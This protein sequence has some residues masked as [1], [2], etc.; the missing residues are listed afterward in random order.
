MIRTFLK[1]TRGIN[2]SIQTQSSFS[3]LNGHQGFHQPPNTIGTTHGSE[4][5]FVRRFKRNMRH[6]T[7]YCQPLCFFEWS[8]SIW[9]PYSTSPDYSNATVFGVR[10]LLSRPARAR[11]CACS[12]SP[13]IRTAPNVPSIRFGK[14]SS[15]YQH[16]HQYACTSQPF[17]FVFRDKC[18]WTYL[19]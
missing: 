3:F 17:E 7:I 18:F 6:L 2:S 11:S 12:V 14:S 19:L 10:S 4:S 15:M 13:F 8:L 9:N 5:L 1:R 16:V